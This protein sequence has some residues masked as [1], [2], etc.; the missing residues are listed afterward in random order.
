MLGLAFSFRGRI[1][2]LQY[3]FGG[4][5]LGVGVVVLVV[6]GILLFGLGS[7]GG[8]SKLTLT[9]FICIGAGLFLWPSLAL[10]TRR[11]RD[12]GWNPVYVVPPWLF[13]N[14][15]DVATALGGGQPQAFSIVAGMVNMGLG[16]C[17]LFWPSQAEAPRAPSSS[18]E[19]WDEPT[20]AP[21]MS[22]APPMAPASPAQPAWTP[23][24]ALRPAV[25]TTSFGRRGL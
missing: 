6:L 14:I 10:R 11:I 2:R 13:L 3:F 4:L 8:M 5:G 23:S 15:F 24:P 17:L 1:N 25:S 20:P 9:L 22:F 12:M 16:S 19:D 21:A 7:A 18:G